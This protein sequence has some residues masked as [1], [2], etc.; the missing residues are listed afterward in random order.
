MAH[1]EENGHAGYGPGHSAQYEKPDEAAL[2]G[3]YRTADSVTIPKDVF[4][5]LYLSPEQ[6]TAGDLRKRFVSV[7][8]SFFLETAAAVS[9][10]RGHAWVLRCIV[11]CCVVLCRA[12]RFCIALRHGVWRCDAVLRRAASDP[13]S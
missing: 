2:L 12:A 7:L 1:F 10:L 11:S 4:E 13:A 5:K 8:L 3:R 6:P 9:L